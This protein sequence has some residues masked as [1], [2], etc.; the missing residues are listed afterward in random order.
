MTWHPAET[1]IMDRQNGTTVLVKAKVCVGWTDIQEVKKG[2]CKRHKDSERHKMTE[3]NRNNEKR[4]M[5]E[6]QTERK[7]INADFH[8]FSNTPRQT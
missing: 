7:K 1:Y 8:V 6:R 2:V 5:R 3:T 4:R